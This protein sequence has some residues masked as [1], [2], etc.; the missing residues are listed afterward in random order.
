[1]EKKGTAQT[2]HSLKCTASLGFNEP[3]KYQ[4]NN[5]QLSILMF[6]SPQIALLRKTVASVL[7]SSALHTSTFFFLLVWLSQLISSVKEHRN[8]QWSFWGDDPLKTHSGKIFRE[9][10]K[11]SLFDMKMTLE[12]I[13]PFEPIYSFKVFSKKGWKI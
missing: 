5:S 9:S 4:R 10:E 11:I 8:L 2:L 3:W 13:L 6:I 12:C 7:C 1:M